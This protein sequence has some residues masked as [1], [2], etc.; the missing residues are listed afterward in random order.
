MSFSADLL[1]LLD[2]AAAGLGPL[3]VSA[4]DLPAPG[5]AAGRDADFGSVTLSDGSVGLFYAWLEGMEDLTAAGQGIMDRPALELV[6]GL[7]G[8]ATGPRALALGIANAMGQALFRSAGWQPPAG[9]DTLTELQLEAGDTVGMVG[10]FPTLVPRL[11]ALKTPLLVVEKRTELACASDT[12]I[13]TTDLT[14]LGNCNKIICTG[15]VLLNDT[16]DEVLAWCRDAE[17]VIMIGPSVACFPDPLFERGCD[18]VGSTEVIQPA[19]LREHLRCGQRWG[20]AVRKYRIEVDRYPGTPAL[21]RR[22]GQEPDTLA[23]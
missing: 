9:R 21:V 5:R 4:V 19:L 1:T 10:Y 16:V 17:Q 18:V 22:L 23:R 7:M 14:R 8:G 20:S 13:V 15:A 11:Q 2:G 3:V 6:R 12:L